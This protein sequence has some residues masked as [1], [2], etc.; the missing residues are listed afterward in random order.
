MRV[1]VVVPAAGES[2]KE[3]TVSA[4]LVASG[5]LI[6]EDQ[7]LVE[8]ETDKANLPVNAS[9][10]G[11]VELLVKE[12][13]DVL[14]G[15]VIARIDSEAK[16]D[17]SHGAA[18]TSKSAPVTQPVKTEPVR[19]KVEA[20]ARA[21]EAAIKMA[22]AAQ[23]TPEFPTSG[24]M[25]PAAGELAAASVPPPASSM[26]LAG[27]PPEASPS[28]QALLEQHQLAPGMV[29]GTGRGGRILKEDVLAH[30]KNPMPS[31][32]LAPPMADLGYAAS[33]PQPIESERETRTKMT[34]LR[35]TIA[36]RL[37]RVKRES[38][39]LTTFNEVDMSHI[40]KLR[41]SYREKFEKAY[42]I[43]L[44]MMSFFVKSVVGAL[45]SIPEVNA[46][47]DGD[48]IVRRHYFDLSVAVG[49]DRG[50]VVPV[51]R[52]CDRLSFAEIEKA[53]AAAAQ[54]AREGSLSLDELEGGCFTITNGGIYGSLMSTPILNPP[55]SAILGMHK[56][57]KRPVVVDNQIVIRPMMY[58]ALSYDH[59]VIDGKEAVSFL[60]KVRLLL[61][62][63]A[64]MLLEL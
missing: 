41:E 35:R 18:A 45:R 64:S 17:P 56:I 7:P 8:L 26:G 27:A 63:P 38:A 61:E 29:F 49:T 19:T 42:G 12:G 43:K 25:A 4:L 3:A 9:C 62:D 44:G 51:V 20:P 14:V 40:M 24:D 48:D 59:R 47:I 23:R 2:I 10:A 32:T 34:R 53:I 60:D 21:K 22:T 30:I 11:R 6:Q 39:M 36:E 15:Q 50:L 1:D 54:R 13:D 57:E 33:L 46:Y 31:P 5:D 55:Q 28:A 37:V 52:D 58:L 16:A